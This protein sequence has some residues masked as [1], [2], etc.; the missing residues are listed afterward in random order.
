MLIL[1]GG[2]CSLKHF[3]I[4]QVDRVET[5]FYVAVFDIVWVF[6]VQIE[7]FLDPSGLDMVEVL[8]VLGLVLFVPF[9]HHVDS[10]AIFD[11]LDGLRQIFGWLGLNVGF[12]DL[13][14][15]I[16]I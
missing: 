6:F 8:F 14:C 2:V 5:E 7:L 16:H 4:V 10:F 12:E 1:V 3:F 15:A 11:F 13:W 9:E